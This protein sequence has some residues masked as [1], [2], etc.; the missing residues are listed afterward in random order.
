M[1]YAIITLVGIVLIL[2]TV[3]IDQYSTIKDLEHSETIA[4]TLRD[5]V[6]YA[7]DYEPYPQE[8]FVWLR[9]W[10]E[11]D[12]EAVRDLLDYQLERAKKNPGY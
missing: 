4:D 1:Q 8:G 9:H 3:I 2:I 6:E 11:G 12:V 10:F 7:L 5:A